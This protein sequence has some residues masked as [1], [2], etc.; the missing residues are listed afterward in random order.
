MLRLPALR[1]RVS[2]GLDLKEVSKGL[3]LSPE[4][5]DVLGRDL[6]ELERQ[7][8]A[9]DQGWAD[10]FDAVARPASRATAGT[11]AGVSR[12]GGWWNTVLQG[13]EWGPGWPSAKI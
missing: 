2:F 9:M 1:R 3:A 4:A 5:Q 7:L 10:F 12:Q 11:S 13:L 6:R 8:Q